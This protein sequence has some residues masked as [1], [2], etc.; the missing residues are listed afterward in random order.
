M[1]VGLTNELVFIYPMFSS[2]IQSKSK[3]REIFMSS[4][5]LPGNRRSR[6]YRRKRNYSF[7]PEHISPLQDKLYNSKEQ[8]RVCGL[9]LLVL[10]ISE[11]AFLGIFTA[12]I[13]TK[14]ETTVEGSDFKK[15]CLD[16]NLDQVRI[17][18][19]SR[20]LVY[21][22]K[23]EPTIKDLVISLKPEDELTQVSFGRYQ[24]LRGGFYCLPGSNFT[25]NWDCNSN[26]EATLE[27]RKFID[28]Y[29][30]NNQQQVSKD[31]L[32]IKSN[33]LT[34]T[35]TVLTGGSYWYCLS[36]DGNKT[37]DLSYSFTMNI[38]RYDLS[39]AHRQ[40]F[41]DNVIEVHKSSW[42]FMLLRNIDQIPLTMLMLN[43][44]LRHTHVNNLM[45]LILTAFIGIC[46]ILVFSRFVKQ[47]L[48]TLYKN[49][50]FQKKC[51]KANKKRLNAK[52]NRIQEQ[53][54]KFRK[55]QEAKLT[56]FLKLSAMRYKCLCISE[57]VSLCQVSNRDL[58]VKTIQRLLTSQ[59]I[60]GGYL[61]PYNT[62][63]FRENVIIN[64]QKNISLIFHSPSSASS[65]SSLSSPSNQSIAY[66]QMSSF[67]NSYREV[68]TS[69][70]SGKK[71]NS[72][73]INPIEQDTY[74]S[75]QFCGYCG[76]II[77]IRQ[78]HFC[79]NCGA[80]IK[81]WRSI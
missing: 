34:Q 22:F 19:R 20:L 39:N 21:L 4:N 42:N 47:I 68:I 10:I 77:T 55:Q 11:I 75:V 18:S 49:L 80:A 9:L 69:H 43:K 24:S 14:V 6:R 45:D 36:N 59:E 48:E 33:N 15:I 65:Q 40:S 1:K 50:I 13:G 7:I 81:S 2:Y 70:N 3:F 73:E 74:K 53:K 60:I 35:F 54:R 38:R 41:S 31:I 28:H 12:N 16:D 57:I 27:I 8:I 30:I 26:L 78:H 79:T 71:A 51:Q 25:F 37:I 67:E 5:N 52:E 32:R 63:F 66:T 23:E 29:E 56:K 17:R 62:V 76:E 61:N 44:N 64:H 72:I 58:I 46:F